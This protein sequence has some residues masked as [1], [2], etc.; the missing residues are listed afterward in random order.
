MRVL[1]PLLLGVLLA[2]LGLW[3]V[4]VGSPS[5]VFI[6]SLSLVVFI[7]LLRHDPLLSFDLLLLLDPVTSFGFIVVR[8]CDSMLSPPLFLDG[9]ILFFAALRRMFRDL[10]VSL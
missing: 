6:N 5:S 8:L 10:F 4:L 2:S 3:L 9:N 1:L 7:K